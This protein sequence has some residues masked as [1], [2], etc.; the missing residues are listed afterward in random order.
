MTK[1]NVAFALGSISLKVAGVVYACQGASANSCDYQSSDTLL[2]VS[3]LASSAN[4]IELTGTGFSSYSTWTSNFLLASILANSVVI[5][6]DTS[7]TATFNNGIP[8]TNGASE[9][10]GK[11]Y[12]QSSSSPQQ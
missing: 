7:A 10:K 4:T 8:L 12:F 5:N 6:S 3:A 11:F 1:E 2:T 9:V